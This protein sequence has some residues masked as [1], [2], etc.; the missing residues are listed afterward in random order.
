MAE[1]AARVCVTLFVPGTAADLEAWR[2]ALAGHGLTL[3][4]A[5]LRGDAL[6]FEVG[7][8]WVGNPGDGSFGRSFPLATVSE[9]ERRTLDAAPG[10]LVLSIPAE[11]HRARAA[12]AA[13]ARALEAAGGL[14]VR[15]EE[16]KLGYPI[17]R[18]IE[19][20]DGT[21]PWSL[22]RTAVV[23]L[24]DA[25]EASTCGMQVF[26]LPDAHVALEGDLDAAA[27]NAL[28]GALNVYQLAEA[29]L[30]L[31]GHTFSPD[32]DTPRRA[33][34]RWPDAAYPAGHPCHN[35]FGVWRLGRPGERGTPPRKL[36]VV[37][38]PTLAATL[39]A[40]EA[41]QGTPLTRAQVEA[42]TAKA[43]CITMEHREAQ[44]VERARGYADLDPELAWEQWQVARRS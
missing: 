13:L 27:A 3:E 4:R 25:G 17:G 32:R 39:T 6:P 37:F 22:Y 5:A 9:A 7:V 15:I 11:L 30:L 36:A 34:R 12:L 24:G 38:M 10:A 16:S 44:E 42:L 20:V 31:G 40:V 1:R 18:W 2:A 29:P 41:R 19:Q 23:L 33:L 14:A 43:P 8:E 28:L 35:P 26:S 21:D